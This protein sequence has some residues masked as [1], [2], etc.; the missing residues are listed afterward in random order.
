MS[1]SAVAMPPA[2]FPFSIPAKPSVAILHPRR[3]S[4]RLRTI[5]LPHRKYP[6]RI[7]GRADVL[8][9]RSEAA[10]DSSILNSREAARHDSSSASSLAAIEDNRSPAS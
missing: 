3:P 5:A 8:I 6:A 9:R 4:Q 10:R 1:P 7:S 2:I